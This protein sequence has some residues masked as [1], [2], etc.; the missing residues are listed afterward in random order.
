MEPDAE[1]KETNTD[2]LATESENDLPIRIPWVD[3]GC[4]RHPGG[5][6]HVRA[7][8]IDHGKHRGADL[9]ADDRH[10]NNRPHHDRIQA[11]SVFLVWVDPRE[12]WWGHRPL[13]EP[14]QLRL[15]G[16]RGP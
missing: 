10:G 1:I 4:G 15:G 12:G 5:S 11:R 2:G 14:H 13:P 3:A 16:I 7:T 9:G 8:R 6:K